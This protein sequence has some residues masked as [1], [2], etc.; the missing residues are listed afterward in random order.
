[1]ADTAQGKV[2]FGKAIGRRLFFLSVHIDTVDV[3]LLGFYKR[4]TLDEHTAGTAAWVIQRAVI[5]LDHRC[6]EL[7][8]IMRRVEFALLFGGIDR[9]FL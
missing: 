6:D 5:R 1:M 9:K 3:T 7:N 4:R 2:H 8:D